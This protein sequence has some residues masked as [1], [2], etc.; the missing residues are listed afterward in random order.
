[1]NKKINLIFYYPREKKLIVLFLLLSSSLIAQSQPEKVTFKIFAPKAAN[2][3]VVGSFNNWNP[4]VNQLSKKDSIWYADILMK[5]GYYYYKF[6]LDG[7]WIPDPANQWRINDGGDN[8]NSILKVGNPP[9]PERKKSFIKFPKEKL[10]QPILADNRD[11]IKLY[12]AAWEMAWNKIEKGTEANGFSTFYM[13]EGFNELIYQW[14]TIFIVAFALY[15][16]DVFPAIQSIDNFYKKQRSDGYIQRVYWETTGEPANEPTK[17]EPMVNPPLFAWIELKNYVL[18]GDKDRIEKVLPHLVKYYDWIENN[19]R[20]SSGKGLYYNTNLGSGM[21]NTP[22]HGVDKAGWIDMSAQQALAALCISELSEIINDTSSA[23]L[24]LKKYIEL[25][26]LINKYCWNHYQQFYFDMTETGNFSLVKHIGAFWTMLTEIPNNE[27]VKDLVKHLANKNEFWRPNLIP[28]LSFD[29]PNYDK[30][31]HY[32]LG[33]VWAPTNYMTVKG[34]EKYGYYDLANHISN[35]YLSTLCAVYFNFVPDEEKIAFEERYDDGYH[36]LWE[37]YSPEFNK[38]ATRWD[39][40]FYSRQDFVG[41]TGLGPIAMLIE[42]IIGI[43]MDVPKN[44]ITWRIYRNDKHGIKNLLFGK[45]KIDLICTPHKNNVE[46]FVS[47]EESFE[48]EIHLG[49]KIIF[50]KINN[51]WNNFEIDF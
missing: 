11:W 44:R 45:Q 26:G 30:K 12:Y 48:L 49:K 31:G 27:Q 2:V 20:D 4:E 10:P 16:R 37:C 41:R 47:A 17:V 21:D 36:T 32:W 29:D 39:N 13:D 3:S 9:K 6:I 50:R 18:T 24:Y 25:K 1:M 40:T 22:R 8:F 23:K 35:N 38:P 43:N 19:L 42:N 28:T 34:L 51:G 14:D 7:I 5:P 33:S 15:A 46:F